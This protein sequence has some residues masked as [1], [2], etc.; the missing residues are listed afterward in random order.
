MLA[1][2]VRVAAALARVLSLPPTWSVRFQ[3]VRTPERIDVSFR[4]EARREG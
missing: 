4:I 2:L 3:A 1:V